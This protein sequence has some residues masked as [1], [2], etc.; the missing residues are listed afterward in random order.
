VKAPLVGG[1]GL[2]TWE[3]AVQ[4]MVWGSTLVTACTSL[5]WNGFEL[6]PKILDGMESYMKEQGFTSYDQMVGK[7]LHNIRPASD[8]EMIPDMPTLDAELCTGCGACL[9]PGHCY[10]IE[11]VDGLPV[12]DGEKC[13]GCSA[14]VALCPTGALYFPGYS[15]KPVHR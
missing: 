2:F 10:A 14:C 9:K 4:Y 3:D 12:V 5:M 8:L 13:I 1:G 11:M 6:I 7:A 15:G